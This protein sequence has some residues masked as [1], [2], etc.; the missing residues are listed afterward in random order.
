MLVRSA[1]FAGDTMFMPDFGTARCDFPGGSAETMYDS[2]QKIFAL[3][4]EMRMFMCHDYLPEGRDEYA[5]ETTIG[6][7]RKNNVHLREGTD[8]ERF[9]Q[10]RTLR[11]T[12]LGMPKLIIPSI[13]V[14]MRAG[15]LP[16]SEGD[17]GVYLKTPVNGVFSKKK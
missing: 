4:N 3:P 10:T 13:Q 1:V 6:E 14:N 5:W 12:E 8:P 17:S 7:Q 9:I 16:D 11:D 15:G 2:T